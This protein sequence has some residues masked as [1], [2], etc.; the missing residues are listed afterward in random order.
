M[1]QTVTA[2]PVGSIQASPATLA[3]ATGGALLAAGAIVVL[4]VMPAEY[5]IDPT[6]V[7]QMTGIVGMAA[8]SETEATPAEAPAAGPVAIAVP[9]KASIIREGEMRSDE[10]TLTL[11]PH[12]G[13]EV[14]AHMPVGGSYVFEWST[15]GGPVKVD[16]H[17]EKANA[18]EGEFTSYWEEKALTGGKGNFTAPFEG[19]H[20][21]YF[22]NKGETPV[23]VTVKTT[24]FYKDLFLPQG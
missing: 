1:I 9:T 5:G 13:Q 18:A 2:N 11:E 4:F 21:W 10:M 3:K 19:T 20:G 22:R 15:K 16:M 23:T 24:G 8:G 17:G 7:G 14:K 6:G 12:S